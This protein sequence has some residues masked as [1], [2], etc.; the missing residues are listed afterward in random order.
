MGFNAAAV[1]PANAAKIVA[2]AVDGVARAC[3]DNTEDRLVRMVREGIDVVKTFVPLE[4]EQ[5]AV[6]APWTEQAAPVV[7]D[8]A[9]VRRPARL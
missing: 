1:R 3:V 6:V 7:E 8:R 2:L 5:V 9:E 4:E